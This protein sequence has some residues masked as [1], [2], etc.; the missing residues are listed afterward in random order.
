MNNNDITR[1]DV[2][3]NSDDYVIPHIDKYKPLNMTGEP[4]PKDGAEP[5]HDPN[6]VFSMEPQPEPVFNEPVYGEPIEPIGNIQGDAALPPDEPVDASPMFE[7]PEKRRGFPEPDT[8]AVFDGD[9]E[10]EGIEENDQA[11]LWSEPSYESAGED[12]ETYTPGRYAYG[13]MNSHNDPEE[14]PVSADVPREKP[15][16]EPREKNRKLNFACAVAICV[17]LSAIVSFI[18]SGVVIENYNENTPR[19]VEIQHSIAHTEA[20][21]GNVGYTGEPLSGHEIHELSKQQ[22]VGVNS[23]VTTT[24]YFGQTTD[25]PVSGSGF[26]ITS[27]GYI[28]TNYHVI[29]YAA[30]YDSKLTVLMY[31]GSSYDAEIIGYVEDND[32]AVIKIQATGLTP[33]VIGNSDEMQ[34]GDT[35]Y[36]VGNPLGELTYTMTDGIVSGLDRVITTRDSITN[37]DNAMNMFQISAAV[38]SGNSGGPVYNIYGEVLGIVTAKSAESNVEGLGFAIPINDAISLATQLMEKGYVSGAVLGVTVT[39]TSKAYS[40]FI[41]EY[42][43]YPDGACILS[44]EENS[45]AENAGLMT[46]DIITGVDDSTIS[47]TDELKLVLRSYNPGDKAALRVYRTNQVLS[48]GNY[49]EIDIVFDAQA[50]Q[51]DADAEESTDSDMSWW[52]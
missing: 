13:A 29:S 51:T 47:S 17:L 10:T 5:V 42:Y 11:G 52:E 35:I 22:M 31:D 19:T 9:N 43:G 8:S 4:N 28:L 30:L 25:T 15:S 23:S 18:I 39:D 40:S 1:D 26:I 49:I 50:P 6:E 38:N 37:Q 20:S 2:P 14:V 45:A 3:N 24:N 34:V 44:V 33:V 48:E 46:G 12:S 32:I 27:D 21:Q 41:C 36:A 7:D 16:E